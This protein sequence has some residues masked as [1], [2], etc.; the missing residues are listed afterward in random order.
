MALKARM[1]A[2]TS[3]AAW[4]IGG[5]C[6]TSRSFISQEPYLEELDEDGAE[7]AELAE[8]FGLELVRR[9]SYLKVVSSSVP[10]VSN[11]GRNVS[12]L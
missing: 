8:E 10:G 7:E 2:S 1:K 12:G 9:G 11:G 5:Y 6:L 4:N 3:V